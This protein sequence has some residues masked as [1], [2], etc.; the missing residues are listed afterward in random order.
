MLDTKITP[1]KNALLKG[2]DN[3]LYA[4][5]QVK[6][7]SEIEITNP[8]KQ[9]NLAI[10]I[11]RSGSMAGYPLE[12]AKKSAIFMVNKM[13]STD[14][15][16]IITYDHHAQVLIPST[17]CEHKASIIN[18]INLINDGGT[19]DL[20]AGWALGAD[21]VSKNKT[22]ESLNRILLLSDGCA[23]CG[24]TDIDQLKAKCVYMAN[25]GVTTSTYGLGHHFNEHLMIEMASGGSGQGYYGET[26]ED[27]LDPFKEEFSLLLNTIATNLKLKFQFPSIVSAKLMNNYEKDNSG[28]I[29]MPDIA[30]GGEVW[31]L[32]K[33]LI[34]KEFIKSKPLEVIRCKLSYN[35]IG[36]DFKKT[37]PVKLILEPLHPNAFQSVAENEKVKSRISEVL[38]AQYQREARDSAYRG[39]WNRVDEIIAQAKK[40]AENN[41]WMLKAISSLEKYSDQR[42]LA[43]FAKEAMYSSDRI[44]KRLVDENED[45][46]DFQLENEK[47]LYLR[48]KSQRGK[49]M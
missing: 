48:R 17:F 15:I 3:E 12:E 11:D 46:W 38:I 9:L 13:K 40:Q 22:S 23:N 1:Q 42:Q 8:N 41:P 25:K 29:Q 31:A 20:H 24:I 4:L 44:E 10:V 32:F 39:D 34:K 36:N 45:T 30:K 47:E 28:N 49:R 26:A 2:F 5:F 14:K 33:I 37:K 6:A 16:S 35:T 21:Q 43:Q 19:T 18:K 7:N 27:L